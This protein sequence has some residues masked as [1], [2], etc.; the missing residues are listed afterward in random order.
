MLKKFLVALAL[1]FTLGCGG[2]KHEDIYVGAP[3]VTLYLV[4]KSSIDNSK[5]P[6]FVEAF[7]AQL[8]NEF[9]AAWTINANIVW[10]DPP[11]SSY[12]TVILLDTFKDQFPSAYTRSLGFH[13]TGTLAYVDVGMCGDDDRLTLACTHEILEMLTN[14]NVA[15]NGYECCDPV[16]P[17][18]YSYK[19][20]DVTVTDFVYPSLYNP[21]APGPYDQTGVVKQSLQPAP[22][23]VLFAT[24]QSMLN[25]SKWKKEIDADRK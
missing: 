5:I 6:K 10:Q 7:N 12:R 16:Y 22:G 9:K 3:P 14:P 25:L 17:L 4:N 11:D 21:M 23:G 2:S 15:S 8:Q 18:V 13:T 20:N 1:F 24:L 19:K